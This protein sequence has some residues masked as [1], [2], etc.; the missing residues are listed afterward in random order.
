M[1]WF[2]VRCIFRFPWEGRTPTYEERVTLW[3]AESA[4]A[5]IELANEEA[6]E[7]VDDLDTDECHVEYLGLAQ[8]YRLAEMPGHGAE[9]FSMMRDSELEPDDY[10]AWFFTTGSERLIEVEGDE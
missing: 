7:Y 8:S 2:G 1:E 4:E 6:R 3:R 9:V 5:A 10:L